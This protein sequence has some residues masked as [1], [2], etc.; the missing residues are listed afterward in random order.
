MKNAYIGID[1]GGTAIKYGIVTENME[2]IEKGKIHT[3]KDLENLI[4][5]IS[6]ICLEII[7]RYT[8]KGIG[9]ATAGAVDTNKNTVFA[10]NLPFKNTPVID[11][12]KK[13]IND[14]PI[15][16]ENDANC[17]ALAELGLSSDANNL[18]VITLGTGIGGGIIIDK[19]IYRGSGGNSGD[20]GHMSINYCGDKCPGCG[21]N[22]C[23]EHYASVTALIKQTK[24]MADNNPKSILADIIEKNNGIVN[25][26]TVFMALDSGCPVAKE[27]FHKY[28][29][30]VAI[31]IKSIS[32]IFNPEKIV[33]SG[34][35][36]VQGDR[37][38]IPIKNML[39]FDTTIEISKLQND[40]GIL[41]A[42]ML[43]F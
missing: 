21:N 2:I 19:K 10:A 25:G 27:V 18:I 43:N 23:W 39:N 6:D 9:I 20:I 4:D 5:S 13:R 7:K 24:E 8:I 26:K 3:P 29:N 36:T 38:L 11:L 12:L 15:T 14:I 22:G 28:V 17:A 42:A 35:I 40:A 1:I 37:L 30:Y 32:S 34:G 33:I 16:V 41:G 31:G